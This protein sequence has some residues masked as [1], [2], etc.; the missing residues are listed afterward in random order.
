MGDTLLAH[1]PAGNFTLSSAPGTPLLFV[2]GGTGFAPVKAMIESLLSA[3]DPGRRIDLVWGNSNPDDFYD[4]DAIAGWLRTH[5]A[6]NVVLAVEH[7]VPPLSPP[8]GVKTVTGRVD[9]ALASLA[10]LAGH[11]AYL[12]GPPAM[13]TG[14]VAA[15]EQAGVPRARTR[16]DSFGG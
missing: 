16:V 10:G 7:A 14:A 2:A 15:L 12:A 8:P 3:P 13:L 4:L 9:Q 6:L 1:G 11:D 5:P